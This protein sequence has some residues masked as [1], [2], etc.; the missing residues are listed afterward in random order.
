M[1]IPNSELLNLTDKVAIVTG[2]AMGIG[3]GIALRLHQAGAK[4]VIADFNQETGQATVA[5]LNTT[6]PDSAIFV[7]TD[8]SQSADIAN[9]VAKTIELFG[10]IDILVNNAGIYPFQP[11]ANMTEEDFMKVINVNLKGTFLCTKFVSD[12]MIKQGQGGK[13]INITSID[14]LHPSMI[15]LAHYDSSK[16][17]MWGFTKNIALELAA[18]KIYV[19]AIAPGGIATPGATPL[20]KAVT[21]A[22]TAK[23]PMKRMGESDEI[24]KVALFLAS[25]MSSYMTG[26]QIVVDGGALLG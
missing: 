19:N 21:D 7:K 22:F 8:V 23:I 11:L 20:D 25:D 17:G 14:A 15:G 18:H 1:N 5:Q 24:G 9:L 16:H 6:R 12:Q 3:Q 26:E 10:K 4:L 13:I 2:A